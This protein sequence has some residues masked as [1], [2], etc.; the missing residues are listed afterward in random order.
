MHLLFTFV[1]FGENNK[2]ILSCWLNY[3]TFVLCYYW[4]IIFYKDL[5]DV[6]NL[7]KEHD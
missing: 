3:H 5:N 2:I 7:L 4:V 6:E 1:L